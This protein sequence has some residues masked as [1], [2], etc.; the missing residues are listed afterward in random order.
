MHLWQ[1]NPECG[2]LILDTSE[3][4]TS[5]QDI[6]VVLAHPDDPEFFCGATLAKWVK[7]GHRVRYFLLT[8]GDKGF[9]AATKTDKLTP[10]QLCR[11]R[12]QEQHEAAQII[13]AEAVQWGSAPDGYLVADLELR[14]TVVRA[15][16]EHKPSILMTCDPQTLFA[17]YG[18]NH[19]DHRAA[20]Q[21][22][23]D[24]AFPA[25]GNAAYFPELLNEGLLPHSLREVWCSLTNQ[26]N[27]T[28]DVTET[29]PTKM[30]ALACHSSQIPDMKELRTR[31]MSRRTAG[32]TEQDPR[33]E[34]TFRV[35]RY[36]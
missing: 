17:T 29:W 24:A 19:P 25:A 21:A 18:I 22:A 16:R 6:L 23:V 26:P 14:K 32:S 2:E 35:V 4:W 10:E 13:G 20:G 34:E 11:L 5:T 1:Q 28:L 9:N 12:H 7:S 8:C 33:F 30:Q 27:M 3:N 31:M 36:N 15:V